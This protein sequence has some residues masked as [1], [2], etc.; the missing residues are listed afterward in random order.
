MRST[1]CRKLLF[2]NVSQDFAITPA[3]KASNVQGVTFAWYP[4]GLN[5][6]HTLGE[7]YLRTV[8][9]YPPM[10]RPDLQNLPRIVY[11]FDSPDMNSGYMYPAMVR[12]FRSVG[13]QFITMFSYDMLE[14]APYNLGWQTHFLNLVYSPRKAVSGH[15]RR[16]SHPRAASLSPVRRLPR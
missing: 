6:G 4:T 14:T 1:G 10:L 15:H 16:G 7:N 13:A 11:E 5:S 3:I 12:T 2:H 9:D 8:D